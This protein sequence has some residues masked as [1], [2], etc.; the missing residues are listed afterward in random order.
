MLCSKNKKE[1]NNLLKIIFPVRT[2]GKKEHYMQIESSETA[3]NSS[4]QGLVIT[5]VFDAPRELV[6][7]A[8]S[9]PEMAK[10]WWGPTNWTAPVIRMDFKVGGTYVMCMSGVMVP[11]GPVVSA[12]STG[13][14]REIVPMEKIIVMDSFADENGNVVPASHYGLPETFPLEAEIRILFEDSEGKTKMTLYY[15]SIEGIEGK[16]LQDMTQGWNQSF[17]KLAEVLKN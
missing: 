10:K 3:S 11:G 9:D 8:W 12:W 2:M 1:D 5:R 7:K 4:G 13:T 16:M 15:P 6:W 17:D 14:Y